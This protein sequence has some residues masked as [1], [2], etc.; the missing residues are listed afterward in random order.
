MGYTTHYKPNLLDQQNLVYE[1]NPAQVRID[2]ALRAFSDNA[3][4]PYILLGMAAGQFA[5]RGAQT[6]CAPFLEK[7]LL[8]EAATLTGKMSALTSRALSFSADVSA[9]EFTHRAL[10]VKFDKADTSLLNWEGPAGLKYGLLHSA[11]NFASLK[12]FGKLG[13]G[14]GCV[15]QHSL[16]SAGLVSAHYVAASLSITPEINDRPLIIQLIEAE[17]L[18]IQQQAM[19]ELL[20]FNYPR[21]DNALVHHRLPSNSKLEASSGRFKTEIMSSGSGSVSH[22]KIHELFLKCTVHFE[23]G[24]N[25]AKNGLDTF[26]GSLNLRLATHPEEP[27]FL[28]PSIEL[29]LTRHFQKIRNAQ[30][31]IERIGVLFEREL[32]ETRR[33][34]ES[35]PPNVADVARQIKNQKEALRNQVEAWENVFSKALSASTFGKEDYLQVQQV[36]GSHFPETLGFFAAEL[37]PFSYSSFDSIAKPHDVSLSKVTIP[38]GLADQIA[39]LQSGWKV[40]QETNDFIIGQVATHF[41][42]LTNAWLSSNP[43]IPFQGSQ[44]HLRA[45]LADAK[46][47]LG[48]MGATRDRAQAFKFEFRKAEI[49]IPESYQEICRS[50]ELYY[51][52]NARA[53]Q[54]FENRLLPLLE[55]PHLSREQLR[56]AQ[57][58]LASMS[59]SRALIL[60]PLRNYPSEPAF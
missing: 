41:V 2:E 11:I 54:T 25:A 28:E 52:M 50:I 19:G 40:D 56:E 24:Q 49:E 17:I 7:I 58:S 47:T 12:G 10:R 1:L 20:F 55:A 32:F 37:L 42:G 35:L 60:P 30:E 21:V 34:R 57:N 59:S 16:Q 15:L 5:A 26:I 14:Q 46:T 31:E 18:N 6:L 33:K 23:I 27:F 53:L 44:V 29:N 43:Q 45:L 38:R 9:F 3:S 39:H 8:G 4:D 36:I 22:S 48:F 51:A 13:E